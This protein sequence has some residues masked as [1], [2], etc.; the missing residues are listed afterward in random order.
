MCGFVI[1]QLEQIFCLARVQLRIRAVGNVAKKFL[2]VFPPIGLWQLQQTRRNR[3]ERRGGLCGSAR[4][5]S[6]MPRVSALLSRRHATTTPGEKLWR[7]I[8][9]LGSVFS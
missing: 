9:I 3:L 4:S 5:L 7:M 8:L 1:P 6:R 2:R